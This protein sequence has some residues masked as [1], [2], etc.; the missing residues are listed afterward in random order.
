LGSPTPA[1]KTKIGDPNLRAKNKAWG[2][3]PPRRKQRL[4]SPTP[5]LK[6]KVGVPDPRAENEVW[7][8]QPP[9]WKQRLGYPTPRAKNEGWS[10]TCHDGKA[11]TL[12]SQ[13]SKYLRTKFMVRDHFTSG[14]TNFA[15]GSPNESQKVRLYW[16]NY[17][18]CVLF[19]YR[20]FGEW[21]ECSFLTNQNG[22][23]LSNQRGSVHK[24]NSLQSICTVYETCQWLAGLW[25]LPVTGDS[26]CWIFKM[27]CVFGLPWFICM[28]YMPVTD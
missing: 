15:T 16:M 22:V 20:A 3:R 25:N 5:V 14:T 19:Y 8:P 24:F 7:G 21:S 23:P 6:T 18:Q 27:P 1:L 11:R 13:F 9:R 10:P 12:E 4:G 2:P 17:F 28:Q 26:Q